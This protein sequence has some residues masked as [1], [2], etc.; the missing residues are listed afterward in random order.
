MI[1]SDYTWQVLI[2]ILTVAVVWLAIWGCF[3]RHYYNEERAKLSEVTMALHRL[4]I[5]TVHS[6][7]QTRLYFIASEIGTDGTLGVEIT[8]G[9]LDTAIRA[10][11]QKNWSIDL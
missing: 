7:P 2:S 10:V 5:T 3:Q 9:N 6:D 1:F 11:Y 4:G 8:N